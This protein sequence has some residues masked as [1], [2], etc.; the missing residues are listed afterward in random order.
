MC[1][2]TRVWGSCMCGSTSLTFPCFIPFC[3]FVLFLNPPKAVC[4][5]RLAACPLRAKP[6][7]ALSGVS[8]SLQSYQP[9]AHRRCPGARTQTRGET[10]SQQDQIGEGGRGYKIQTT[11]ETGARKETNLL[12][13]S[14]AKDQI[15]HRSAY[16]PFC[17]LKT[18]Q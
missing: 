7:D 6:G 4:R 16:V 5:G 17:S 18:R 11:R 15:L 14:R 9:R 2:H 3:R 13:T 8:A 10:A 1:I 12:R